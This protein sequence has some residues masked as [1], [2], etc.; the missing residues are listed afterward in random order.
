MKLSCCIWALAG[1]EQTKLTEAAR[2][3]FHQIDIQPGMLVDGATR[4]LAASLELTVRCVG[5]SFGLAAD[6]ALDS[7]DKAARQRASEQ[8]HA[9]LAE[10]AQLGA[11]VAYVVPTFAAE[12]AALARYGASL[13]QLA[14]AAASYGIKVCIEHFPGRALPTA[15]ETLAFIDKLGHDNLYLLLDLGHLQMSG[16]DPAA[17]IQ[18]AGDRLG[19]VHLDDND[20][21]GD[22]HWAL[23][24]GV[25]TEASLCAAIAALREVGYAGPLSLELSPHLPD[26]PAALTHSATTVRRL[27]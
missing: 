26:V 20:G 5:L 19:Y 8:A 1:D 22:L 2:L 25:M 17:V 7:A 10:A 14:K 13:Q 4:A 24:D 15:A 18:V 9:G 12:P 6:V 27:L 23:L 21:V 3:G 11:D 16:E